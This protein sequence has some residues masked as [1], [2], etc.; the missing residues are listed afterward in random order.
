VEAKPLRE[1]AVTHAILG[2]AIEVHSM[3]GPGLLES[4]YDKCLCHEFEARRIPFLRQVPMPLQ[5]KDLHV[6]CAY[7]LDYVVKQSVVVE[8]KSVDQ[9]LP[10]HEAQLI[11]YLRLGR[12]PVGLL[13]NF[14]VRRL[15]EGILRRVL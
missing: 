10:V 14:N 13:I 11:T 8:I 7:R 3:L 4:A 15:R 12:F 5:F 2:A 1:E 9:V 6:R